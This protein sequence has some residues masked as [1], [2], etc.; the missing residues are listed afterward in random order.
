MDSKGRMS[1]ALVLLTLIIMAG[2][3]YWVYTSW[4]EI[5]IQTPGNGNGGTS[6]TNGTGGKLGVGVT[7][8]F[9]DGTAQ[10]V[11]PS[12]I[13]YTLFPLTVYFEGRQVSKITWHCYVQLDW[14]GDI[15]SLELR[16]PMEVKSETVTLRREGMLKT[17]S[18]SDL[19]A[20]NAWF[21]MW[22]FSLDA[23]EIEYSLGDGDFTL[24]CTANVTATAMFSTGQTSIKT[25][26]AKGNLPITI[27]AAGLTALLCD[28]Q[29]QIF[30]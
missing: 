19:P 20:K 17:Y 16:G 15:T 26:S 8:E 4:P 13:Q 12:Q 24:T 21:E 5:G 14:I 27:E 18:S 23:A 9:A 28:V 22:K 6:T 25:A 11:D 2:I 3:F 29:V 7:I 30:N 10:T 1:L